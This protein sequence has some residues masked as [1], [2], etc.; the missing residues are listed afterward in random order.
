MTVVEIRP[1][2]ARGSIPAPPSKSYTH[3]ALVVGHLAHR[4]YTVRRPLDADDTRATARALSALGSRVRFGRDR[5]TISPRTRLDRTPS[6]I[7]CGESGTTLRFVAAAAALSDRVVRLNGRGRLPERP[8]AALFG[9]LEE[10]GATIDRPAV[11][12]G[13]PAVVRG[14][15]HG[16]SVR[17]DASQSSQFVSALLLVLP[18]VT[19]VSRVDLVGPIVSEPYIRSTL[20]VLR[21]HGIRLQARARG[22]RV[23]GDQR[24]RGRGFTVPGDASSAAYL[25]TAAAVTG[26]RVRVA[27]IPSGLPQADLTVLDLLRR[28]GAHVR[29]SGT[30]AT[31]TAR[32]LHAFRMNLTPAPDLYP[33]AGVLAASIPATSHLAGAAHVI[34][35]ES[36][37]REGTTILARAMGARVRRE[38]TGLAIQGRSPPTHFRLRGLADHRLVMSAAVGALAADGRS[39][40][41]DARSVAKSFP[42]FWT[43]LASLRTEVPG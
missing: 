39:T 20:A 2:V 14:P 21:R 6:A 34:H 36:D 19:G 16:G 13:L 31:V 27:G 10:L 25:W 7:D 41:G 22:F 32:K 17:L 15:I 12:R 33:L 30:G 28:A 37:R 18:T 4:E 23:P 5:W 11:G 38:G 42:G 8:I 24:Y 26:G 1:G 40:I 29:R 3:R 35:K 43:A 9:A